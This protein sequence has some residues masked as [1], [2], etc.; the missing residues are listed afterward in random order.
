MACRAAQFSCVRSEIFLKSLARAEL[1][2]RLKWMTRFCELS[3]GQ[4]KKQLFALSRPRLA[5]YSPRRIDRLHARIS[6]TVQHPLVQSRCRCRPGLLEKVGRRV[7]KQG[8]MRTC[9]ALAGLA[10]PSRVLA[11]G[12]GNHRA[13]ATHEGG[14]RG[15]R[16]PVTHSSSAFPDYARDPRPRSPLMGR[17]R[18]VVA[19][20][21]LRVRLPNRR[22][23][24]IPGASRTGISLALYKH[25]IR[26]G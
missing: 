26:P 10:P 21:D 7:Q 11:A 1:R 15:G 2:R 16:M 4:G 19:Y 9:Y 8:V 17:L 12:C 20:R 18:T 22:R 13:R 23:E 5:I 24:R 25:W 14:H 3:R 6:G